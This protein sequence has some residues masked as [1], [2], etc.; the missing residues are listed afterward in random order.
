MTTELDNADREDIDRDEQVLLLRDDGRTY[1]T[2]S[3]QLDLERAV[4]ARACYL[5]AL[6][7]RPLEERR[8]LCRREL[9]R[10]D[11]FAALVAKR[12]DL[13]AQEIDQRLRLVDQLRREL[14]AD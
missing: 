2:I 10:L 13:D 8:H 11:A 1:A 6:R 14:P 7:R 3:K 5:R 4:I 9:Q 12:P